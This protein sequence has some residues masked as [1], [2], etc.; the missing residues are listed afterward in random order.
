MIATLRA[1]QLFLIL[2]VAVG[3]PTA[4]SAQLFPSSCTT[5]AQCPDGFSC[6]TEFLGSRILSVRILQFGC[7]VFQTGQLMY[8]GDM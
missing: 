7:R 1:V 8:L 5:T 6:Q 2:F 4:A 3:F